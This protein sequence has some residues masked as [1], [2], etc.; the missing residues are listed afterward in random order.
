MG[1]NV[2]IFMESYKNLTLDAV[3]SDAGNDLS[4]TTCTASVAKGRR[5]RG[6]GNARQKVFAREV[7]AGR[8]NFH[9]SFCFVFA[10]GTLLGKVNPRLEGKANV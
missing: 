8:K 6:R 5:K 3:F 4:K 2:R 10:N 1:L 7:R 9:L